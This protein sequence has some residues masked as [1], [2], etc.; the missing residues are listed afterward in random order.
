MCIVYLHT[1]SYARAINGTDYQSKC[2]R[3]RTSVR[4]K[5]RPQSR[6]EQRLYNSYHYYYCHFVRTPALPRL[7]DVFL[8]CRVKPLKR[9]TFAQLRI[10]IFLLS[11]TTTTS[12]TYAIWIW[13]QSRYKNFDLLFKHLLFFFPC[14]VPTAFDHTLLIVICYIFIE[15]KKDRKKNPLEN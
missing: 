11:T 5:K 15:V 13:T 3:Q 2:S 8:N 1:F 12:T 6:R 10:A 7:F 4:L 9:K 14:P